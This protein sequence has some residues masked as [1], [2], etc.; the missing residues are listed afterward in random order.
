M[1]ENESG[2]DNPYT[3][4]KKQ[5]RQEWF[6]GQV[7]ERHG[8]RG[9]LVGGGTETQNL[10]EDLQWCFINGQFIACVILSASVVE[11][12]LV[13]E[14]GFTDFSYPESEP[15]LGRAIGDAEDAGIVTEGVSDLRWLADTRNRYV[16]FRD[17]RTGDSPGLERIQEV[18]LGD[19]NPNR[20]GE[21]DAR[22]AIPIAIDQQSRYWDD[23]HEAIEKELDMDELYEQRRE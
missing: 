3:L 2:I 22:K 16:H 14:L 7:E 8:E 18:K 4:E 15:T 11:H 6:L 12:L 1:D 10:Y 21:E 5:A 19:F 13:L 23:F 20:I 9:L 17:G